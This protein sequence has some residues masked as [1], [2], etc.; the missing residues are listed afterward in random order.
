MIITKKTNSVIGSKYLSHAVAMVRAITSSVGSAKKFIDGFL[1]EG[2]KVGNLR[3]ASVLDMPI[4]VVQ[5]NN[6]VRDGT[7]TPY[8]TYWLGARDGIMPKIDGALGIAFGENNF[9]VS[10]KSIGVSYVPP[11][12]YFAGQPILTDDYA[13]S[14]CLIDEF[15]YSNQHFINPCL[16]LMTAGNVQQ[17]PKNQSLLIATSFLDSYLGGSKILPPPLDVRTRE[18]AGT[19]ISRNYLGRCLNSEPKPIGWAVGN[20]TFLLTTFTT[21]GSNGLIWEDGSTLPDQTY[22]SNT[23]R[24]LLVSTEVVAAGTS[25]GLAEL[26]LMSFLPAYNYATIKLKKPWRKFNKITDQYGNESYVLDDAGVIE[27]TV[28]N[29]RQIRIKSAMQNDDGSIT[30][31]A[32]LKTFIPLDIPWDGMDEVTDAGKWHLPVFGKK[33]LPYYQN[34]ISDCYGIYDNNESAYIAVLALKI[35]IKDEQVQSVSVLDSDAIASKELI[36]LIGGAHSFDLDLF[37]ADFSLDVLA[38]NKVLCRKKLIKRPDKQKQFNCSWYSDNGER[39]HA[40]MP[41]YYKAILDGVDVSAVVESGTDDALSH[42]GKAYLLYLDDNPDAK[43]PTP[44][45]RVSAN[46]TAFIWYEPRMDGALAKAALMFTDGV[47]F[48][49]ELIDYADAGTTFGISCPQRQFKNA[50][51][52][53]LSAPTVIVTMMKQGKYVAVTRKGAIWSEDEAE[54]GVGRWS[55]PEDLSQEFSTTGSL[56]VIGAQTFNRKHGKFFYEGES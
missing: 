19:G 6:A 25:F 51:N 46:T 12:Y 44:A 49:K 5:V 20:S 26:N 53:I 52:E 56:Y 50:N 34:W 30:I 4:K 18:I 40:H 23:D 41:P 48:K 9:Y 28:N 2:K 15:R 1:I 3:V 55:E 29:S 13:C 36:G 10:A 38:G 7:F 42:N 31:G 27:K 47:R 33:I 45:A 24:L 54:F 43:V 21:Q 32:V 11:K 35:V 17:K 14:V 39:F 37:S 22:T 8:C 16:V